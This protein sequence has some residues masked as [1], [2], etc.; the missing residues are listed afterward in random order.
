MAKT[1]VRGHFREN[2]AKREYISEEK[3]KRSKIYYMG[4]NFDDD[5]W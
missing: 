4:V 5:F 3:T 2:S 1:Y